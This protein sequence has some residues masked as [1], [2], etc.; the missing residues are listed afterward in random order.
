MSSRHWAREQKSLTTLLP[1]VHYSFQ[2]DYIV[3]SSILFITSRLAHM[4]K[5]CMV[6]TPISQSLS[7][8]YHFNLLLS[9]FIL[10]HCLSSNFI[11]FHWQSS[12]F[13]LSHLL[14][15]SFILQSVYIFLYNSSAAHLCRHVCSCLFSP[16]LSEIRFDLE[17]QEAPWPWHY[18]SG[19]RPWLRL[20]FRFEKLCSNFLL[21]PFFPKTNNVLFT[22]YI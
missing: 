9:S 3:T 13:N 20:W 17:K 2:P 14:S 19:K 1:P 12:F 21:Q 7:T 6:Y 22:I 5:V 15:S 4:V 10:C 11:P 16:N 8:L 18:P